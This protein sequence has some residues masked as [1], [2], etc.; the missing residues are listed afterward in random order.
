MFFGI[1]FSSFNSWTLRLYVKI[2]VSPSPAHY[3]K[4]SHTTF[5]T[6]GDILPMCTPPINKMLNFKFLSTVLSTLFPCKILGIIQ[7]RFLFL[8][9]RED[10]II[11]YGTKSLC[12]PSLQ[13]WIPDLSF[14]FS[15]NKWNN[16]IQKLSLGYR[17][18][19]FVRMVPGMRSGTIYFHL[20]SYVLSCP[21]E[22]MLLCGLDYP[23]NRYIIIFCNFVIMKYWNDQGPPSGTTF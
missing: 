7:I 12:G 2:A 17:I 18:S 11:H 9:S 13:H 1:L 4:P 16:W 8:C 22:F 6:G 19:S 21:V 5:I 3:T 23:V 20:G 15:Y 14:K 10:Y